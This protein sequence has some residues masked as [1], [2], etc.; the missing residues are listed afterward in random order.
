MTPNPSPLRILIPFVFH[1]YAYPI[2]GKTNLLPNPSVEIGDRGGALGYRG[3]P[4][5]GKTRAEGKLL[6]TNEAH[7]G[8]AALAMIRLNDGGL[9]GVYPPFTPIPPT[10]AVRYFKASVWMKAI[11]VQGSIAAN[12]QCADAKW[13]KGYHKYYGEVNS[14]WSEYSLLIQLDPGQDLTQFRIAIGY[15]LTLI[16]DTMLLD[17][18]GMRE[19]DAAEFARETVLQQA[20]GTIAW[21][22]ATPVSKP[23]GTN[24]LRNASFEGSLEHWGFSYT[25][26]SR[27]RDDQMF[28]DNREKVHGAQS[29][30]YDAWPRWYEAGG[31]IQSPAVAV[32]KGKVYTLSAF[33][34]TSEPGIEAVLEARYAARSRPAITKAVRLTGDWQRVAFS[35]EVGACPKGTMVACIA[36]P[37]TWLKTNDFS[38]R[39]VWIDAVQL[40]EGG[41]SPFDLA[42]AVEIVGSTSAEH[43]L[44]VEGET[45][46]LNAR[47]SVPEGRATDRASPWNLDLA[48]ENVFGEIVHARS[49]PMDEKGVATFTRSVAWKTPL[50]GSFCAQWTLRAGSAVLSRGIA[51][52][53]ILPRGLPEARRGA[54][55]FGV[56]TF[57]SETFCRIA[58]KIG[59]GSLRLHDDNYLRWAMLQPER[60]QAPRWEPAKEAVLRRAKEAGI[61][62]LAN[63]ELGSMWASTAP[64]TV[65]EWERTKHPPEP[66]PWRDFSA[67]LAGRFRGLVDAWEI[68]NEPYLQDWWRG[69]PQQ[70]VDL[71]AIS[72][73]EI[74]KADAVTPVVGVCGTL[75]ER[76]WNTDCLAA[77]A[78]QQIDVFSH[79]AYLSSGSAGPEEEW[80]SNI[81]ANR[82][83]ILANGKNLPIWNTEC[84]VGDGHESYYSPFYSGVK[85]PKRLAPA[86]LAQAYATALAAGI[87]RLY[88]YDLAEDN[89]PAATGGLQMLEYNGLPKPVVPAFA[90]SIQFLSG[91]R[92]VRSLA[93]DGQ[94][95]CFLF[96]GEG[97]SLAVAW[98]RIGAPEGR[99]AIGVDGVSVRDLMGNP[100]PRS[101]EKTVVKLDSYPRYLQ[102]KGNA[103]R[104]AAA[105]AP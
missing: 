67:A 87:E 34:K 37:G 48:V 39:K 14:E 97:D 88:W 92:F 2:D 89:G 80:A 75:Y 64:A 36:M 17:D 58:G 5:P 85:A 54:G 66:G 78:A 101:G 7:T 9:F 18:F 71:L 68:W 42:P 19:L 10:D 93:L 51:P 11:A 22:A 49:L 45:V 20:A 60:G 28:L 63:M 86:L 27:S 100:L 44:Y 57:S 104:L 41:L 95:A 55:L 26:Q 31:R 30:R 62:L 73:E 46:S 81:E 6:S 4:I 82:R 12:I 33:L 40:E 79:H 84:G 3:E 83:R 103:E 50:L 76:G 35:F 15:G 32:A 59:V 23:T 16:G 94:T 1:L 61:H 77:G 65:K 90:A 52:F 21:T 91:K 38:A 56:N 25:M 72:R 13:A 53:A 29:M 105:L 96:E 69:S 47:M 8:S 24:L 43:G 102:M 99:L 74:K 98:R 70:Y